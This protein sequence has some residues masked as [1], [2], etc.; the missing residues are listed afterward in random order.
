MD[1]AADSLITAFDYVLARLTGRLT[2]LS[3]EEYF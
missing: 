2:G 3:D 1:A